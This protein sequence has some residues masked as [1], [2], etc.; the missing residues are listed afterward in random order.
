MF[1]YPIKKP[2]CVGFFIANARYYLAAGGVVVVVV[3]V[4]V[5]AAS[6]AAVTAGAAAAGASTAGAGAGAGLLQAVK[7]NAN[8][9]AIRAERVMFNPFKV[10]E[11][12]AKN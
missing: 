2:T 1:K 8:R 4:V 3:V 5:T 11:K 10:D 7:V 9:A 12:M 6:D